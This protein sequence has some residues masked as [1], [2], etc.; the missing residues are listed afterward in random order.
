MSRDLFN[1]KEIDLKN[2]VIPSDYGKNRNL[3]RFILEE[4]EEVETSTLNW[5][6]TNLIN[7][8]SK[9]NDT[10]SY[11]RKYVWKEI[12]KYNL[13]YS[14]LKGEYINPI[15]LV[16]YKNSK[17][18][19]GFRWYLLDG[20]QRIKALQ[21]FVEDK[22]SIMLCIDGEIRDWTWSEIRESA[23][24]YTQFL[25]EKFENYNLQI[26]MYEHIPVRVQA[27]IFRRINYHRG[28]SGQEIMYGEDFFVKE[29][30][31]SV[32]SLFF[33]KANEKWLCK[34]VENP[35]DRILLVHKILLTCY[36]NDFSKSYSAV[37]LTLR[38]IQEYENIEKSKKRRA[39]HLEESS[40]V[41][42]NAIMEIDREKSV[43]FEMISKKNLSDILHSLNC[44]KN[45][46]RCA[47][48]M[49]IMTEILKLVNSSQPYG[50]VNL[51]Y[52]KTS[53]NN[54]LDFMVFLIRKDQSGEITPSFVMENID[55]FRKIYSLMVTRRSNYEEVKKSTTN[56]KGIKLR[57]EMLDD[58]YRK[59]IDDKGEK[60]KNFTEEEKHIAEIN[61]NGLCFYCQ[62]PLDEDYQ[63]DHVEPKSKSSGK[64][65]VLT[66]RHC[67]ANKGNL[68]EK[69]LEM[70]LEAIKKQKSEK[71][72]TI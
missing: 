65:A 11:Q 26:T 28:F 44:Y 60:N 27:R 67:N 14:I 49:D 32:I 39:C 6:M 18:L 57:Q 64:I 41:I 20:K 22:F 61:S 13:I 3:D 31:F 58:I 29:F 33:G 47:K 63:F 70:Y 71:E 68:T 46:S 23:H 15:R 48:Y 62:S 66:H 4:E 2:C 55:C 12:A 5:T 52:K 59:V 40:I 17:E 34:I 8:S 1:K 54:I 35:I 25:K 19:I 10:V 37:D 42:H 38:Q 9:I 43:H 7:Y 53:K 72:M 16:K 45:L 36:G 50:K 69:Q 30:L 51:I 24:P 56:V 21:D